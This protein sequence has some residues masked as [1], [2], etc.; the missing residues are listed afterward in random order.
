[1]PVSPEVLIARIRAAMATAGL[2]QHDL[3]LAIGLDPSALSKALGGIRNFKSLEVALIAEQLNV[4]VQSL[5]SEAAPEAAALAARAQPDASPAIDLAVER[6]GFLLELERLLT[7]LGVGWSPR[8]GDVSALSGTAWEQGVELSTRVR[9]TMGIGDEDLPYELGDLSDLLEKS[10]AIDVG[11]EPLPVGLDG[12]SARSG[13]FRLALVS[14]GISGTRQRFTLAHEVGHLVAG[15]SQELLVDESVFGRKT[16]AESRAN[17]FAAAFLMPAAALHAAVP[18]GG[19]SEEIV[20]ALLGRFGVSLDALAFRLHNVDVVDA[21]GRDRIRSM[22]SNRIALR[23]GRATDLQARNDRRVPG[24]LLGRAIEAYVEGRIS[25]RPLAE[26]LRVE[27]DQL[28]EELR[29]P[30][31]VSA[32]GDADPQEPAL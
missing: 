7:D 13:G 8:L 23:S 29:W 15:D 12:L 28:L 32:R 10:L 4:S 16:P 24:N 31:K 26:L 3:A 25:V 20:A 21:A 27:P 18:Y 30:R 9:A 5:L 6:A 17:A 19:V 22:S 14:S 1:M 11:F 2:S